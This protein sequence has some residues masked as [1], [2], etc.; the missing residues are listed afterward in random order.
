MTLPVPL[1]TIPVPDPLPNLPN[2]PDYS[3][4]SGDQPSP[5]TGIAT[6]TAITQP[7]T[8]PEQCNYQHV[9]GIQPGHCLHDMELGTNALYSTATP[10]GIL[11]SIFITLALMD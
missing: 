11:A 4:G 3:A 6:A 8:L 1:P 2:T 7:S 10:A 5:C 9:A